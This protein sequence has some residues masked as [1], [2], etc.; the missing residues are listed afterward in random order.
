MENETSDVQPECQGPLQDSPQVTILV[1]A[2]AVLSAEN[3]GK[4][5]GR[6]FA[7]NPTGR[8]HS[9]PSD[10]QLVGRRLLPLPNNPIPPL[11]AFVTIRI[12]S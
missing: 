10:P 11:S 12:M 3:S 6:C 9:A 2:D 5:S 7:P 8:A 1:S 4:H